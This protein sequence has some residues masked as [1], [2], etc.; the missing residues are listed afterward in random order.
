[1]R[2]TLATVAAATA[3][4][5]MSVAPA[6]AG[7]DK[8]AICHYD[9][10]QG[11]KYHFQSISWNAI[12]EEGH[13]NHGKD[14]IPPFERDDV[15][16]FAGQNWDERGQR[17]FNAGCEVENLPEVGAAEN[18]TLLA[19]GGTALLGAGWYLTKGVGRRKASA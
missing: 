4:L 3:M 8:H 11:G 6:H 9:N 14:I 2:R 18:L 1:M 7:N 12:K 10:G 5:G 15:Q 13:R 17:L 19:V 16:I